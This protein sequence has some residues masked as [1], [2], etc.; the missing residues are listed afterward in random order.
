MEVFE[1]EMLKS[2]EDFKKNLKLEW[3][4]MGIVMSI[5]Q[6]A[7]WDV[8]T[9]DWT[10]AFSLIDLLYK[11]MDE[12]TYQIIRALYGKARPDLMVKDNHGYTCFIEVKTKSERKFWVDEDHYE[13]Y[14]D[15]KDFLNCD[16][17]IVFYVKSE[18]SLYFHKAQDDLDD[19]MMNHLAFDF[20]GKP[21]LDLDYPRKVKR[22]RQREELPTLMKE[23]K[24]A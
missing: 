23:F 8:R 22:V 4:G 10:M 19:L 9:F 20:N 15:W 1:R 11:D 12:E 18:D 5:F 16:L 3:D 2:F 17:F 7:G 14:L 13:S 6:S 24:I 21:I